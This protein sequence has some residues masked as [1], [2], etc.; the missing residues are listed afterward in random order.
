MKKQA[1]VS[2]GVQ[3][4]HEKKQTIRFGWS[5]AHPRGLIVLCQLKHILMNISLFF[6][7]FVPFQNFYLFWLFIFIS[8]SLASHPPATWFSSLMIFG[9]CVSRH[10]IFFSLFFR[11]FQVFMFFFE[12]CMLKLVLSFC[13]HTHTRLFSYIRARKGETLS[14]YNSLVT[15]A[16]SPYSRTGSD[17]NEQ[18]SSM[19]TIN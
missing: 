10:F 14:I 2:K 13:A 9:T 5:P 8:L 4:A 19:E 6:R 12:C 1:Q 7:F 11:N 17:I 16:R 18:I 3:T 15:G